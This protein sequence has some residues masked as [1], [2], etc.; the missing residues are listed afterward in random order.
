[1]FVA[2][3]RDAKWADK[4]V[5]SIDVLICTSYD[6]QLPIEEYFRVLKPHGTLVQVG[7]PECGFPAFNFFPM[8][9]KGLKISGS[10]I[11]SP[12]EIEEMLQLAVEKGVRSWIEVWPMRKVNQAL[13]AF[14]RGQ[15]RYR[16]VLANEKHLKGSVVS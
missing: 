11:G 6:P 8:L 12:A 7:A 16:F 9:R 4:H 3:K 10:L 1:M 5:N 15:P 13:A 14:N 2:A